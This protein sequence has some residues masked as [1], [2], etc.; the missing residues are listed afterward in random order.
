MEQLR[1]CVSGQKCGLDSLS[2]LHDRD[3]DVRAEICRFPLFY[4]RLG[5]LVIS[6][7]PSAWL[8]L[9]MRRRI[10]ARRYK[11]VTSIRIPSARSRR[12]QPNAKEAQCTNEKSRGRETERQQV[13]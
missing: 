12:P 8:S 6:R 13:A 2:H 7:L 4:R 3:S 9:P 11:N 10:G 5:F 1:V